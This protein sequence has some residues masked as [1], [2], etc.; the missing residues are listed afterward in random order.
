MGSYLSI[1]VEKHIVATRE[2]GLE[3][4]CDQHLGIGGAK[5]SLF[6]T[7]TRL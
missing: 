6:Q 4:L 3:C 5:A 7:M 1:A 2:R